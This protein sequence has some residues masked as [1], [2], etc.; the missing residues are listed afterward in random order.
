MNPPPTFA[1]LLRTAIAESGLSLAAVA[2]KA[3]ISTQGL[4]GLL[5][6]KSPM[7]S[8]VQRLALALGI[9][10]ERLRDIRNLD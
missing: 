1:D 3:G 2:R 9:S 8:T 5:A 6:G 7:W 4:Y 10:T